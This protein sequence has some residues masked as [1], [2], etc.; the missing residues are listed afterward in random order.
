MTAEANAVPEEIKI[1]EKKIVKAKDEK[2]EITM[3]SQQLRKASI[4]EK[5]RTRKFV[6][7]S[8]K[9]VEEVNAIR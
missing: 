1:D 9:N 8:I 5:Q 4:M 2:L 3:S 6:R 7:E